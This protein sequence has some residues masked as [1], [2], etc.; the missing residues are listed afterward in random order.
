MDVKQVGDLVRI[1]KEIILTD[2][3]SGFTFKIKEGYYGKV[4]NVYNRIDYSYS[5]EEVKFYNVRI[6]VDI[7]SMVSVEFSRIFREDDLG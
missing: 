7:N 6:K 3:Y 5:E 4:M 1:K 2:Y